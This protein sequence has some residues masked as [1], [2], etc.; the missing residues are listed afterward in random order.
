MKEAGPE[1]GSHRKPAQGKFEGGE[2]PHPLAKID[3]DIPFLN[4]AL[5]H[6]SYINL[7]FCQCNSSY[8][9]LQRSKFGRDWSVFQLKI[10]KSVTRVGK[11]RLRHGW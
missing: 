4:I 2:N 7:K 6:K 8:K 3:Y 10:I 11:N 5:L 1:V 9:S